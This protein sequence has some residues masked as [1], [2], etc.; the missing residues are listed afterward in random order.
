M[1]D[2]HEIAWAAGLFDGEGTAFASKTMKR[3]R[4]NVR[5]HMSVRMTTRS[6]IERFARAVCLGVVRGP[7]RRDDPKRKP[8]WAWVAGTEADVRQCIALL[9]PFLG[10]NKRAQAQVAIAVRDDHLANPEPLNLKKAACGRGHDQ[11]IY[12]RVYSG[13]SSHCAAC[14]RI[15]NAAWR[16]RKKA[17]DA[18]L[19]ASVEVVG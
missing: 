6:D 14:A 5:L 19:L 15:I 11:A 12:R 17:G 2:S 10:S 8:I 3:A 9:W 4:V 7:Y 1:T 18:P 16:A 13:G